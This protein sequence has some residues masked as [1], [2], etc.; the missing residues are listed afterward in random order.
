[1]FRD[2]FLKHRIFSGTE[3]LFFFFFAYV[4]KETTF[5]EKLFKHTK[6]KITF[7][8]RNSIELNLRKKNI[9]CYKLLSGF[10]SRNI[11]SSFSVCRKLINIS[12]K[13]KYRSVAEG[14]QIN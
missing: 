2:V 1:M 11:H 3:K 13:C 5:I 7:Q 9:Y 12:E 6:L 14:T 4:G 10:I 8:T